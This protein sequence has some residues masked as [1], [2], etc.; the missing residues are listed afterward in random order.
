MTPLSVVD[1]GKHWI[2]WKRWFPFFV[3]LQWRHNGCDG[4]SNHQP[5]DCLINRLFRRRSK[6]TSKL[7]VTG[8]CVGNSPVTGEF[9]AQMASNAE[10]AFFWWR[11]HELSIFP[12]VPDIPHPRRRVV[13]NLGGHRFVTYEATLSRIP[14][15]RL[16]LLASDPD[17]D[18]DAKENE[19]FFDRY[20]ISHPKRHIMP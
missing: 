6:K 2:R 3:T 1:L 12:Q 13:L 10:N 19:Y 15:S 8:L 16:A 4:V 9:P 11:N 5:H 17:L 18:Y 20:T 7:R 14:E